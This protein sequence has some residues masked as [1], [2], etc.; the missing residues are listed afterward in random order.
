MISP[1]PSDS[2]QELSAGHG[3]EGIYTLEMTAHVSGVHTETLLHYYEQGLIQSVTAE[4]SK[5]DLFNDETVHRLRRIEH[6]RESFGMDL[7]ALK[8]TLELMDEIDHLRA[9]LRCRR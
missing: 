9:E 6:L 5:A 3:L 7:A 2:S 1:V 8:L 4:A